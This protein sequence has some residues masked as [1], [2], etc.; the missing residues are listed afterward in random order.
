MAWDTSAY[1]P[2]PRRMAVIAGTTFTQ[3]VRMKVFLFLGIFAF[4]LLALSSFRLTEVLGPETGGINE[5]ILLKSSAYGAIRIFGLFFCVAATALIIPKDAED[6]ILYTILCKPVPRI[7]YLMGK[8]LGVLVLTLI[9]VLVM[10]AVMNV[11]LWFRTETVVN[12]QI[13]L[14]KNR[15]SL[16]EMQ[17]YLDRIREQGVTWNLQKGVLVMMCEFAVLS[18]LTLLFSCITTGTIISSLLTLCVYIAG[19]FQAQAIAMWTSSSAGSSYMG[20]IAMKLFSLIFPNFS[21]FGITDS[22][23][24]GKDIPLNIL[25]G[26][27]LISLAYFVF[28]L[29]LASWLFRKREF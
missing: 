24:N 16:E 1:I 3:L 4:G 12:E 8:V 20:S 19:L 27:L 13:L 29:T 10:D 11:V 6:R 14:L 17:P 25:G 2:S 18:S 5:L 23:L 28:H 15:Y 7:D 22:A 9:A 21:L 26:I